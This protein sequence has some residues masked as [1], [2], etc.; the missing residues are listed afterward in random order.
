MTNKT[1][2][3]LTLFAATAL[4]VCSLQAAVPL[5]PVSSNTLATSMGNRGSFAPVFSADGR[6]VVFVS[7]ADD[8]VTDDDHAPFLDVFVRDL[9]SGKTVLASVNATGVGGGDDNANYPSISSDGR[10]VAFANPAS[11]LVPDDANGASDIFV[12][13][14]LAGTTVLVSAD[15]N[16]QAPAVSDPRC[17]SANP[18]VSANG[19]WVFFESAASGL[20]STT[21]A[22]GTWGVFVRDLQAGRTELVSV[23][24]SGTATVEPSVQSMLASIT[25]DG[26]MA[27][28]TSTAT[29][30]VVGATSARREVYVRNVPGG[31]TLWA[32]QNVGAYLAGDFRSFDP[33]LSANGRYVAFKATLPANQPVLVFRHD[34]ETGTTTL[35]A[36]NSVFT[37]S[38]DISS[39]GRFV[40]Y[41]TDANVYV[42]DAQTGAATL[43]S[44]NRSGSGPGNGE[45]GTPVLAANGRSVAFLSAA[46]DL[47]PQAG[48]GSVHTYVRDIA[49]ATTRLVSAKPDGT[50]SAANLALILPALSA[51]GAWAAYDTEATD[52]GATDANQASDVFARTIGFIDSDNDGMDDDWEMAN[53]GTLARDGTADYDLDGMTDLQEF[54]A[55]TNPASNS[56]L[57]RATVG[58][59]VTIRWTAEPGKSYKVQYQQSVAGSNWNDL[60]GTVVVEGS[61]G[62]QVDS[63]AG[64]QGQRFYRVV[65]VP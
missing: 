43:A 60:P 58:T 9:I 55:G 47:G 14:L 27:A 17:G 46:T 45:S 10:F 52:L 56:S 38:P 7:C 42:W 24:L 20:V 53:F 35:L 34:L 1:F 50:P 62:W 39:D 26:R 16:G 40:A 18:L 48:N 23:K 15:T 3:S 59:S 25:P 54:L 13:D 49:L 12:R 57:L 32:S 41:E 30:L 64:T 65:A 44:V 29:G 6:F 31:V 11:N 36:S 37:S 22:D 19:R 33:V 2:Q 51:N 5:V 61:T 28:F 21:D 4:T 8:L 63:S